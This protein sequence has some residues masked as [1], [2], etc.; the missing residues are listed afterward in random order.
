MRLLITFPTLLFPS[1]YMPAFAQN[2]T[3]SKFH[4]VGGSRSLATSAI[5][6]AKRPNHKNCR[7]SLSSQPIVT[8]LASKCAAF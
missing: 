4:P 8:K 5:F 2:L 1:L 3:F 6:G 7:H